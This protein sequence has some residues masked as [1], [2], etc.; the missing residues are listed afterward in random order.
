MNYYLLGQCK[1][2]NDENKYINLQ[3]NQ[4]LKKLTYY[5]TIIN[6]IEPI[7]S[8]IKKQLQNIE[9]SSEGKEESLEAE[10]EEEEYEI[11]PNQ[12]AEGE[13][14]NESEDQ[15]IKP[16]ENDNEEMEDIEDLEAP[17]EPWNKHLEINQKQKEAKENGFEEIENM[18]MFGEKEEEESEEE[19]EEAEVKEV[20]KIIE[21]VVKKQKKVSKRTHLSANVDDLVSEEDEPSKKKKQKK[22]QKI[23]KTTVE[24]EEDNE[25]FGGFEN[26]IDEEEQSKINDEKQ[27]LINEERQK[28]RE[29]KE[30]M[31]KKRKERI[32][33]ELEAQN[34][35]INRNM[36]RTIMKGKGIYRKRAKKFRNPRVKHKMKY[37]EALT[38]R[39]RLVQEYKEGPQQKYGGE[40]TGIR[41]NL[42]RSEKF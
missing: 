1:L 30:L 38:K 23:K 25:K 18:L 37:Q 31:K 3:E 36:N 22:K 10:G 11:D 4:V 39:R 13:F 35:A 21:K 12:E 17:E 28:K 20:N 27:E 29:E 40:L 34:E 16:V 41:S 2:L 9:V 19:H 14:D 15:I 32:E 5:R 24:V 6:Q 8:Q 42:V 33:A 7:D 26:E